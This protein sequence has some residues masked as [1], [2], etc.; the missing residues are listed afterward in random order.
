MTKEEKQ[1]SLDKY[2]KILS[3]LKHIDHELDSGCSYC[4]SERG[5][6]CKKCAL[7]I[8]GSGCTFGTTHPYMRMLT[9]IEAAQGNAEIIR[10]MIIKDMDK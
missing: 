2:N 5:N 8:N 3:L 9:D 7:Q 6:G 1:V 4:V 10:D